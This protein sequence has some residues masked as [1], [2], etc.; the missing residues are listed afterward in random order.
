MN[1]SSPKH[2]QPEEGRKEP[3]PRAIRFR[4][5]RVETTIRERAGSSQEGRKRAK[6]TPGSFLFFLFLIQDVIAKSIRAMDEAG[7]SHG[8]KQREATPQ[9]AKAF[10]AFARRKNGRGIF[11]SL[12]SLSHRRE[13]LSDCGLSPTLP[14]FD[15]SRRW[16]FAPLFWLHMLLGERIHAPR[17]SRAGVDEGGT[18][19]F[20]NLYY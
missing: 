14:E 5:S 7:V 10:C 12:V 17:K 16:L 19:L 8:V 18:L 3:A 11:R 9:S 13:S 4:K 6:D 20:E 15:C 2:V 1:W